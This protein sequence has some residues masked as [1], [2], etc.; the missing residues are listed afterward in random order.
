MSHL[1]GLFRGHTSGLGCAPPRGR[2]PLP[3]VSRGGVCE[4]HSHSASSPSGGTQPHTQAEHPSVAAELAR[5]HLTD[6]MEGLGLTGQPAEGLQQLDLKGRCWASP[7]LGWWAS[8]EEG[9]HLSEA[10]G[11]GRG[12]AR[13]TPAERP[14][15]PTCHP[16][17][18]HRMPLWLRG[19][20]GVPS[21]LL[22][23]PEGRAGSVQL[24][25][26]LL[27]TVTCTGRAGGPLPPLGS[28]GVSNWEDNGQRWRLRFHSGPGPLL[29][30]L[31]SVWAPCGRSEAREGGAPREGGRGAAR[32]A[33]Q[34]LPGP[35]GSRRA[36]T[37]AEGP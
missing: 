1:G 29:A 12:H 3:C 9:L 27:L 5:H 18:S 33:Q 23:G 28:S 35:R 10:G 2:P 30:A 21:D 37:R 8:S 36:R 4:V 19:H 24:S 31:E 13:V 32:R 26:S 25:V 6:A 17:H 20:S 14:R 7:L 15:D 16:K 22:S 11:R 34:V